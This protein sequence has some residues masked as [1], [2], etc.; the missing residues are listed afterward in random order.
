M[1]SEEDLAAALGAAIADGHSASSAVRLVRDQTGAAKRDLYDL[2]VQL[3]EGDA[4]RQAHSDSDA[5]HD[6][7]N[8]KLRH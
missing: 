5:D 6:R 3:A 8:N 1:S 2:A 7:L 4:A